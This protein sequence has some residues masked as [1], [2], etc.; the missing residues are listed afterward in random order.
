VDRGD[1]DGIGFEFEPPYVGVD[2]DHCRNADTG[3]IEQ[4]A[5]DM[6][7]HLDSYTE[8]SLSGT[9]LHIIVKG[10][11]PPGRRRCGG[12]EMYDGGRYFTMS[13]R[14]VEGSPL[15]IEDRTGELAEIHAAVFAEPAASHFPPSESTPSAISDDDIPLKASTAKNGAKFSKLWAGDWQELYGS[16][17]EADQALCCDLAFWTGRD[18][19]RMDALFR[20]SG[21][22]REKWEREDYRTKTLHNAIASTGETYQ[23]KPAAPPNTLKPQFSVGDTLKAIRQRPPESYDKQ[24]IKYLIEPEIPKG[25]LVM[26]T[27]KPGCGKTTL[28]MHWCNKMANDGNEVLY[29]DRD[30]PLFIAQERIERFGGRT[31]PGLMYWGLWSK[32]ENGEPLEPPYPDSV[33]LRDAVKE[34]KNPVLV[35]DTLATFCTGDEN[36][37]SIMGATF[38][39][40]RYLANLGATVIMIHHTPKGDG[41]DYRGA[42]AMEG[43]VDALIKIVSTIEEGKLTRM[44]VQTKKTRIGDGKSI[45]YGIVDGVPVRQTA[46]FQDMLFELL[47]RN[48]GLSKEKFED[49]ARRSGFRRGT[50]RDFIDNGTTAG[51]IKYESRK[52]Y[53]KEATTTKAA[54]L[55]AEDDE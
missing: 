34:M 52:L 14:H 22:Y 15:T 38:K 26:V 4:W 40:L 42:S 18:V 53:V 49:V 9:G 32:D 45:V 7:A 47:K 39:S 46:T 24:E 25:A 33:F 36:D 50:I 12:I 10:T 31:A 51:K 6:V 1:Y 29:L 41:S 23:Q 16:Q 48:P 27:G 3:E 30:N 21:L 2:L 20:Q 13:G 19:N 17:S 55:F 8:V 28:V 44:E 54:V 11:L 35:F 37:N 43:A 5:S